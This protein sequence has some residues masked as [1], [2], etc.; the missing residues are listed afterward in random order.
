[1]PFEFA[2]HTQTCV[3][4][5]C[6]VSHKRVHLNNNINNSKRCSVDC[7]TFWMHHSQN[8][9]NTVGL[10]NNSTKKIFRSK[11]KSNKYMNA[12]D[13]IVTDSMSSSFLVWSFSNDWTANWMLSSWLAGLFYFHTWR[14]LEFSIFWLLLQL[15]L[16]L[17]FLFRV[18]FRCFIFVCL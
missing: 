9:L 18:K 5:F 1:M 15:L 14:L 12:F 16:R 10:V 13:F 7:C 3:V 8:A 17:R 6:L 11:K 4:V 2:H